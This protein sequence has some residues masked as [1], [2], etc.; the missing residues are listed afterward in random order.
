MAEVR[1]GI[2][3]FLLVADASGVGEV[4]PRTCRRYV[5]NTDLKGEAARSMFR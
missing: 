1:G 2:V 4:G 5:R 3:G